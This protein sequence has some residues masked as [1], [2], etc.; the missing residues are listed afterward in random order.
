MYQPQT[1]LIATSPRFR[2]RRLAEIELGQLV[3]LA[4]GNDATGGASLG[5]RGDA[6]SRRGEI[7][8]GVFRLSSTSV[9]FERHALDEGLAALEIEYELQVDLTG[10]MSQARRPGDLLVRLPGAHTSLVV[11]GPW[12]GLGLLDLGS[13]VARAYGEEPPHTR[14]IALSWRLVDRQD[15]SHVLF[16]RAPPERAPEPPLKRP[17]DEDSD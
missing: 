1:P 3:L 12:D 8:E 16:R 5:I 11:T 10:P 9:V 17:L 6:L 2:N 13:A 15:R 7:I 4:E 14:S